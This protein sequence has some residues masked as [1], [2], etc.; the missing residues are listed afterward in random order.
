MITLLRVDGKQMLFT[1]D[2]GVPALERV[3]R[4]RRSRVVR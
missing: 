2:A 4:G 1:A 3:G